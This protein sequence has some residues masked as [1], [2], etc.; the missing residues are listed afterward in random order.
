MNLLKFAPDVAAALQA[1]G[2]T[3]QPR[4]EGPFVAA[5]QAD[6]YLPPE[7]VRQFLRLFGGLV[8]HRTVPL[9]RDWFDFDVARSVANIY[10]E[11][12]AALSED[13]GQPLYPVGEADCANTTLLMNSQGR[14]FAD[15][16]G[17]L[18]FVGA[19]VAEA[20]KAL[21]RGSRRTRLRDWDGWPDRKHDAES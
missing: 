14:L 10:P 13:L 20:L 21:V 18:A 11:R 1:T 8:I 3:G 17:G 19:S 9:G 5:L 7:T 16:G 12:V 2:W 4:D 15:W 6:G